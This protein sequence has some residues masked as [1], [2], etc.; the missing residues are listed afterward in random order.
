[1]GISRL[2]VEQTTDSAEND[3][4]DSIPRA[5]TAGE[6][7]KKTMGNQLVETIKN[8]DMGTVEMTPC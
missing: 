5:W 7:N 3:E 8:I 4:I 6:T 2:N 1:M